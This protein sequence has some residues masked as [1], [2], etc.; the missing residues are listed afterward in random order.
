MIVLSWIWGIVKSVLNTIARVVVFAVILVVIL[1]G[2]GL[3]SGDGL[4]SNMVLELDARKSIEDKTASSLLDLGERSLSVMDIVMGL[5]AA[6]RAAAFA[7]H[8]KLTY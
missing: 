8:T 1:V 3:V 6:E 5:D 7:H 2:I 4:P